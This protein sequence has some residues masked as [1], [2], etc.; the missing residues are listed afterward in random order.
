MD[1]TPPIRATD[2]KTLPYLNRELSWLEFNSR[3]LN[4]ALDE[5][6]PILERVRFMSIFASNLDEFYMVRVAGKKRASREGLAT[7]DSPDQS[8]SHE[9]LSSIRQRCADLVQSQYQNY[10]HSLLPRLQ[11]HGI[12]IKRLS[13]LSVDQQKQLAEYFTESIF[14][15]LTPLAVDPAHPF[16]FLANLRSYLLVTFT[17]PKVSGEQLAVSFVEI[18]AVLP[19]LIKVENQ[20]NRHQFLFLEDLIIHHLP[21]LFFG[22]EIATVYHI[23]VT[24]DLDFT[25]LENEVVDLLQSVQNKVRAREQAQIIR[26]EVSDDLPKQLEEYLH[27]TLCISGEDVFRY[28]GPLAL[29]D[30]VILCQLP[31]DH[32]KYEP[33]NPRLPQP[34]SGSRSI[35]SIIQQEDLLIHHP[36]ESFYTVIELLNAAANDPKVIAIKQTLYR[37]SGENSPIIDALIQAA[38]NGKQVTVVL[39]LKARFDE[40]NNITWARRMERSGVNVV[41]GFVG[42]KTHAKIT[43]IIRRED[44]KVRRYLHLSTGNYNWATARSYCDVGFMTADPSL[45]DDVSELFNLLTGFNLLSEQRIFDNPSLPKFRKIKISPLNLREHILDL[46]DREINCCNEGK[47]GLI[48]AKMNALVDK[49]IIDKLYE[50]SQAGVTI[51]LIIRGICCL[52]PQVPGL[53]ENIRVRSLIDRF[54][55]HSRIIYFANGEQSPEVYLSSADWMPRNMDRRIEIFFPIESE[56]LRQRLVDEIL[57]TY[58]DDNQKAQFL[59][60][61]GQYVPIR[62]APDAQEVRAQKKFIELARQKGLK[63]LP[64]E[65][66]VRHNPKLTGRPVI[67]GAWPKKVL[68]LSRTQKKDPK[69]R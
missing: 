6:T 51:E 62:P 58:L 47:R 10:S 31:L 25:L 68:K 44:S 34:L 69:N 2:N 24:R 9:I 39:E 65:K 50:A 18:P 61:E 59:T 37:V 23:R 67:K 33:F 12:E 16:P 63:S 21:R 45:C 46:I 53:S 32:L 56:N 43:L 17:N 5:S 42:L 14:P 22:L 3:V 30:L 38:E 26:L 66:A 49:K 40:K 7:S 48:I 64:Y 35:F 8:P 28:P 11:E 20:E 1:A 36:Y 15:V 27:Q 52:R 29:N 54:L 13:E 55:E 19:R 4:E 41:Y 60:Q 57:Q